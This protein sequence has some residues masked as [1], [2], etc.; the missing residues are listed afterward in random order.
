LPE[1]FPSPS[2]DTVGLPVSVVTGTLVTDQSVGIG[3]TP[4]VAQR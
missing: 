3:D 4:S 1:R 2:E